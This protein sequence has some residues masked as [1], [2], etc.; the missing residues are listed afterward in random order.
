MKRVTFRTEDD[1]ADL[2]PL[3]GELAEGATLLQTGL[4]KNTG[5]EVISSVRLRVT[6]NQ[7]LPATVAV[8]VNG[9][10]LTEVEQEVLTAPLPPLSSVPLLLT[11]T[12]GESI[13][14]GEDSAR[15]DGSVA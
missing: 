1:T 2:P 8:T 10:T 9:V 5:D 14:A 11:W 4:L 6:N 15:I 3:A 13:L 12:A 7:D